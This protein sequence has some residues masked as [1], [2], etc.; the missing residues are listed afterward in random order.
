MALVDGAPWE[1]ITDLRWTHA[2]I[3][4]GRVYDVDALYRAVGVTRR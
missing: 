1:R 4:S 3:L 2:V